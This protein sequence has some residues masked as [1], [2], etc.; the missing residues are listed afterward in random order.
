MSNDELIFGKDNTK[1]I[2][3][4]EPE[5]GFV[6]IFTEDKNGI[7]QH[8]VDHKYWI[9]GDQNYG[10]KFKKLEGT[11]HYKYICEF[12]S[13]D[14]WNN[15]RGYK[16]KRNYDL[17]SIFDPKES[18]MVRNGFTYFKDMKIEDV[19]VL[20]FDIETNGIAKNKDSIIYTIANAY[21]KDGKITKK[22][23]S[24]D[25][26]NGNMK[27][28]LLAWMEWVQEFDPS[29][30]LGHNIYGF[31]LPFIDHCLNLCHLDFRIGRDNRIA[32]FNEKSS[33]FRK[34]GSQEYE[35]FNC[36]I[37]GR[38]LVDTFFLSIKYDISRQ[39]ESYGLKPIIKQ[40][41][42]E[43][44][45]RTFIDASKISEL[46]EIPEER[47][48][49]KQY[50]LDDVDDSLILYD[51]FIPAFFYMTQSIPKAFQ[52]II[53]SASGSQLNAMMVR[54]YLQ[55]NN[56]IAKSSEVGRFE[57]GAVLG[58]PG[59]YKNSKKIDIKSAHPSTI[60]SYKLFDKQ[61]D[62]NGHFLTFTQYFF[63]SRIKYKNLGKKTNDPYY[64]GLDACF[65]VL[66]NSLFGLCGTNGLNY[67]A[68][69][70]AEF[71]TRKSREYI[72]TAIEWAT[73]K[74]VDYW[75]GLCEL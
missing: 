29:V 4:V 21:R 69:D 46:W 50:N 6:T 42:L 1:N 14:Q 38:E 64:L 36:H 67:N 75:K 5:D 24:I 15:A 28:M 60:L 65:K 11:N 49:I 39:F 33:K 41:G 10:G 58:I 74:N 45:D 44:E 70:I 68:P 2:V 57:G 34:D 66:L 71:I 16:W 61:K 63:D 47:E 51:K 7:K 25:D 23:F 22:L 55:N 73:S 43:K 9:L 31:D 53:N 18:F 62:P 37:Y 20:S 72:A 40:L 13:R 35:F 8:K 56:S 52:Q 3:S 12:D 19:S 32:R 54:S 30:I 48:R 27:N 59:R 26:Y 17:Y